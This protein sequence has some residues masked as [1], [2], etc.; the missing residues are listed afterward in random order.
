MLQKARK[1]WVCRTW[2]FFLVLFSAMNVPVSEADSDTNHETHHATSKNASL[3]PSKSG[4]VDALFVSKEGDAYYP[5]NPAFYVGGDIYT[6]LA[7][8]EDTGGALAFLDFYVPPHDVFPQHTH[9][10]EAESKYILE[11]EATFEFGDVS[12]TSPT[13]TFVYYAIGRQMGF[14]ATNQ[15]ARMA[16]LATPGASYYELAGVPV[17]DTQG[18]NIP[19]PEA[20][21]LVLQQQIDLGNVARIN[22][23]YGGSLFFPGISPPA[24]PGL[25]NT[26]LILPHLDDV[27]PVQL[28]AVQGLEGVSVFE[29]SDRP[30]FTDDFGA[31]HTA[32]V[33]SAETGG[34]LS[35]SQF[36]LE[37][38][39]TT[40]PD[41]IVSNDH[42]TIVV[43]AGELWVKINGEEKVAK[44]DAFIYISPGQ[45]YAIA[46]FGQ[47]P[48]SAIM[49]TVVD[50]YVPKIGEYYAGNIPFTASVLEGDE[51]IQGRVVSTVPKAI[52]EGWVYTW[53]AFDEQGNPTSI[54]FT[55]TEEVIK[56]AF[57]VKDSN[58]EFPRSVPQLAFPDIFDPTSIFNIEFPKRVQDSTPFNHIGFH[59]N[60]SGHA[61][62]SVFDLPHF[63]ISF[64]LSTIQDRERITGL[65]ED[66]D[67]LFDFPE[68]GFLPSNYIALMVPDTDIPA[69]GGA[70]QGLTWVPEF[71]PALSGAKF[72][73]IFTFGS[74]DDKVNFWGPMV[75]PKFLAGL[76][77]NGQVI[78]RQ[79]FAIKQPQRFLTNGYYPLTYSIHYNGNHGEY[80][81]AF[82]ELTLEPPI[83]IDR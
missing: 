36:S 62:E 48:A 53:G 63:D 27:D 25:L 60:A 44:P 17:V 68:D 73:Q 21:L 49:S 65:P 38:Q 77:K 66:N 71:A 28:R 56:D 29:L 59:A 40:F 70:L 54:G 30:T 81:I 78:N 24:E 23:I 52:G 3:Q 74:Y 50:F 18:K 8:A 58:N 6:V 72:N 1:L 83:D 33:T 45:T 80:T 32:L 61:P 11:G 79:E 15:P 47:T 76:A 41:S 34:E 75:T 19:P 10:H 82:D 42:H 13:G 4:L 2:I 57:L 37:P 39:A 26:I 55:L 31:K 5:N 46:N 12:L 16:V 22:D 7:T 35:Y 43:T 20:N 64:F 69:A 67:N 51:Y 14:T 9:A